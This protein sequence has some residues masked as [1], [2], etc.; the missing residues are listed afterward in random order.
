MVLLC[1]NNDAKH[2]HRVHSPLPETDN[3]QTGEPEEGEKC[4][5]LRTKTWLNHSCSAVRSVFSLQS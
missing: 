3:P 5:V 1:E 2:N 4:S